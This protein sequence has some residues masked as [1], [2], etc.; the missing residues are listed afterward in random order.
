MSL[1]VR[2]AIFGY[3]L[4]ME[5]RQLRHFAAVAVH[6]NFSKAARHF[7]LTQPALSR[8]VRALE[9]ELG[10]KLIDRR[11]NSMSLTPIGQ[12][13]FEQTKEVLTFLDQAVRRVKNARKKS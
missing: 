7:H 1:F 4:A 13:Y 9:A 2:I 3:Y 5:L 8:Q 10:V 12:R 6:G 11:K